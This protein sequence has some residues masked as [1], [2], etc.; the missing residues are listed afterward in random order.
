MDVGPRRRLRRGVAVVASRLPSLT[1]SPGDRL[2]ANFAIC[3][4]PN[5]HRYAATSWV[6]LKWAIVS[7]GVALG[8]TAIR[9]LRAARVTAALAAA[10]WIVGFAWLLADS[11]AAGL[12]H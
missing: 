5:G 1:C 12:L 6:W 4:G 9:S 3:I 7:A 2:D 10:A 11:L 8:P